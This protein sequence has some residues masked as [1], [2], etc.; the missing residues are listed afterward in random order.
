MES[1]PLVSIGMPVCNADKFLAKTIESVLSQEYTSYELIISDNASQDKTR[2]IC[3]EYAKRDSRITYLRNEINIGPTN[4]FSRCFESSSGVFF[5]WAA[6][7]DLWHPQFLTI[8]MQELIKTE[9]VVLCYPRT[10]YIDVNDR[11]IQLTPD[12]L[13]TRGMGAVE[14]FIKVMWELN[15]CNLVYGLFRA[16]VLRNINL[17]KKLLAADLVFVAELSLYGTIAQIDMPLFY[18]RENRPG[19]DPQSA[20][21]RQIES[22]GMSGLARIV[23]RTLMAYEY[24][25][26]IKE[27][28]LTPQE[29]EFLFSEIRKCLPARFGYEIKAE[30]FQLIK[31]GYKIIYES[32]DLSLSQL[33]LCT[34]LAT[35]SNY[36]KFFY[37]DVEELN[38]FILCIEK[39][40]K[41]V[42]LK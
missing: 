42:Q 7:H 21:Q 6:D 13:D 19:E 32:Q 22:I 10:V 41:V 36:C 39:L 23:P 12:V 38:D 33:V 5:M 37:G 29:K 30:V 20:R 35:L 34:E 24:V 15:W 1:T 25:N 2:E 40:S 27:S 26:I 14:R 9:S 18:R 17:T 11:P 31:Q 16:S 28:K 4:N 8:L 3:L